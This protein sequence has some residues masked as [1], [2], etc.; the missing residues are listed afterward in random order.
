MGDNNNQSGN[1]LKRNW[2]RGK[3]EVGLSG[4]VALIP[5]WRLLIFVSSTFTGTHRERD[6]LQFHILK[7][8]S[9]EADK[10]G[11]VISFS[12]MRWGIPGSTS[13]EHGTWMTC[14]KELER[15]YHQSDGI[16]FLSLQSEKYLNE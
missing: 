15:C 4:G 14:R 8:L 11:I 5:S 7:K 10:H 2:L 1:E 6:E 9:Q 3:Y 12:D 16:F 13:V